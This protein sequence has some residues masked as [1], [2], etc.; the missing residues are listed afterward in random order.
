M[1]KKNKCVTLG[2]TSEKDGIIFSCTAGD[3]DYGHDGFY[4]C[5]FTEGYKNRCP[6]MSEGDC[7]ST[8]A[9]FHALTTLSECVAI[10][11]E[12]IVKSYDSDGD[13]DDS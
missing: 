12:R 11:M 8:M 7:N 6:C 10:E 4:G 3:P 5:D 1:K 13:S 2:E 9:R